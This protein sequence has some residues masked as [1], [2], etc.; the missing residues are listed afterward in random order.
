MKYETELRS[1]PNSKV[2]STT[3]GKNEIITNKEAFS[4]NEP[5]LYWGGF[6]ILKRNLK[7]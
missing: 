5:S 1:L 6:E 4:Y 3:I 2:K 7:L